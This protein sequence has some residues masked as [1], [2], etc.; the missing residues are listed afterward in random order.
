MEARIKELEIRHNAMKKKQLLSGL[1]VRD[2]TKF[3]RLRQ[4]EQEKDIFKESESDGEV[5]TQQSSKT[6]TKSLVED[7]AELQEL[8]LEEAGLHGRQISDEN[9]KLLT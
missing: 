1:D 9:L 8:K 3:E 2:H 5:F 4:L 6:A 7:Q